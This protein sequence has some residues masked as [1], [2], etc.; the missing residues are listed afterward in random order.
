MGWR[1]A[2]LTPHGP[3]AVDVP[4]KC[5]R[6]EEQSVWVAATCG[7]VIIYQSLQ[8]IGV[9]PSSSAI[10]ANTNS[11]IWVS[12]GELRSFLCVDS[13]GGFIFGHHFRVCTASFHRWF[14]IRVIA[15]CEYPWDWHRLARAKIEISRVVMRQ[16][17]DGLHF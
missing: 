6:K 12:L 8:V 9:E 2:R 16:I 17:F 3:Q 1:C 5:E 15:L 10:H 14:P 11:I 13:A 7:G 4:K